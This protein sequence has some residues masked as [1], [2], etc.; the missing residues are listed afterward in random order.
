MGVLVE[1]TSSSVAVAVA[2]PV[3]VALDVADPVAVALDVEVAVGVLVAVK[4]I[5]AVVVAPGDLE[6]SLDRVAVDV[7]EGVDVALDVRE[8]G[9]KGMPEKTTLSMKTEPALIVA[10]EG[11]SR[12]ATPPVQT[13]GSPCAV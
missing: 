9:Y 11:T 5:T 4:V 7:A 1:A 3:A 6:G 2:D 13:S 12:T 8:A 10:A